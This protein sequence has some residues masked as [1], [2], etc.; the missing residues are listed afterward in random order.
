MGEKGVFSD[1][2]RRGEYDGRQTEQRAEDNLLMFYH[3]V[4]IGHKLQRVGENKTVT[5]RLV[6]Y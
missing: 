2:L 6:R 1:V 5:H 3:G 4:G